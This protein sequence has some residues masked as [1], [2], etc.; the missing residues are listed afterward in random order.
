MAP[1]FREEEK[2]R[3]QVALRFFS[4]V[5]WCGDFLPWWDA[6]WSDRASG[7]ALAQ[8]S[9]ELVQGVL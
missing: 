5:Q 3:R 9:G 1:D 2:G 4:E 7:L 6:R 8:A